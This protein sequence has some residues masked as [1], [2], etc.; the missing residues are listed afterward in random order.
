MAMQ[1]SA[2][3]YP[4]AVTL[5][6]KRTILVEGPSDKG[7]VTKL[8]MTLR[9]LQ[10]ASTDNLVIDTAQDVPDASGGNRARVEAMHATVGGSAKFAAFVDREFRN[11]DMQTVD[12]H[13]P[14]HAEIPNYLFWTRGHSIENYFSDSD[15]VIACLEQHYPEHLPERYS[16][17]V[18]NAFPSILRSAASITLALEP[19]DPAAL[20]SDR[21]SRVS[22]IKQLDLWRVLP[23]GS[24]EIDVAAFEAAL[25]GRGF[26]QLQATAFSQ[27]QAAFISILQ[28]KDL[29]VSKWICHGHLADSH[30][31]SALGALLQHG[32]ME[33]R[34][35]TQIAWGNRQAQGRTVADHWSIS[36]AADEGEPPAA[37][38]NWLCA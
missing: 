11:F 19:N 32:G 20:P 27:R 15:F 31:W 29:S 1:Y 25:T 33:S 38:I 3:G 21:L 22:S 26:S 37:L 24:V 14:R 9:R 17:V 36:C 4:S 6:S 5:R 28:R 23:D 7:I 18:S 13:A 12:D 10:R 35:A 8:F 30:V 34:Y 2:S 16:Q